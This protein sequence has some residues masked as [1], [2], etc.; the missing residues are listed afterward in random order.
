MEYRPLMFALKML[1]VSS[2][3]VFRS[4]YSFL[5]LLILILSLHLSADLNMGFVSPTDFLKGPVPCFINSLYWF[6]FVCLL[7]LFPGCYSFSLFPVCHEMKWCSPAQTLGYVIMFCPYAGSQQWDHL[8]MDWVSKTYEPKEIL[9]PPSRIVRYSITA[10][11][12]QAVIVIPVFFRAL[13]CSSMSPERSGYHYIIEAGI[14]FS[15]SI[16]WDFSENPLSN[17]HDQ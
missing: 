2:V 7:F 9:L 1:W 17:M 8:I 4:F 13:Q 10:M 3:S 5:I 15:Q 12:A 11:K 6:L 14:F 16:Y